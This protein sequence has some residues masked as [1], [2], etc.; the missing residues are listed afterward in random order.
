MAFEIS[1]I[2]YSQIDPTFLPGY[3]YEDRYHNMGQLQTPYFGK[4]PGQLGDYGPPQRTEYYTPSNP[5]Y[6]YVLDRD[7][8][9]SQYIPGNACC[10]PRP[11]YTPCYKG[12]YPGAYEDYVPGNYFEPTGIRMPSGHATPPPQYGSLLPPS[13]GGKEGYQKLKVANAPLVNSNNF[14]H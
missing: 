7:F 11:G 4:K 12:S 6:P 10:Y 9:A 8:R 1:K 13:S 3:P 5:N 14:P 2:G